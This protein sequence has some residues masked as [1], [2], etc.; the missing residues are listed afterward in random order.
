M[1]L[2]L[3]WK[4]CA[5]TSFNSRS[6]VRMSTRAVLHQ[7]LFKGSTECL[8]QHSSWLKPSCFSCH[9]ATSQAQCHALTANPATVSSP[10]AKARHLIPSKHDPRQRRQ[11]SFALLP[12]TIRS[13]LVSCSRMGN[14]PVSCFWRAASK[15]LVPMSAV[16]SNASSLSTFHRSVRPCLL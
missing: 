14:I 9:E 3:G 6:V 10:T 11:T 5:H 16:S 12:S 1:F 13:S 2:G 4:L 8:R 15:N 7:C